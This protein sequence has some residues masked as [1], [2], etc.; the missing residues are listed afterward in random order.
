M[1]LRLAERLGIPL[2]EGARGEDRGVAGGDEQGVALAQGDAEALGE[3]QQ[4]GLRAEALRAAPAGPP[5]D[6]LRIWRRRRHLSQLDLALEPPG[7]PG[8]GPGRRGSTRRRPGRSRRRRAGRCARAGTL[9][10]ANAAVAPLL[11]GV[12]PALLAGPVNVLRLS[13]HG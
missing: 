10:A 5:G 3:A 7:G 13:L 12:D 8:R 6:I 4:H 1:L 9:I 2:R 11:D